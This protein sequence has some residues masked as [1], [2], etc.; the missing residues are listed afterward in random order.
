MVS[1]GPGALSIM[2]KARGT[3]GGRVAHCPP[4]EL[5]L[6]AAEGFPSPQASLPSAAQSLRPVP[7]ASVPLRNRA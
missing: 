5:Q 3:P 4:Q 1:Q 7:R 2:H 6:G